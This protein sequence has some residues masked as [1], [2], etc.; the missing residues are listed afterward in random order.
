MSVAGV[1]V[2]HGPDPALARGVAA[3]GPQVDELVV[4]ANPPAPETDARLIVNERPLG[5]AAN[6][7]K[8]IAA[9][10]APFVVLANPDTEPEPGAVAALMEFAEAHPLAGIVGPRLVF[11]DGRPQSSRR[12][13]PTVSGTLVRRTPL[14]RV[15]AGTQGTHYGL[16]EQ[17]VGPVEADWLLGAFVLLRR[18]ML[19]ELGGFDDRF[20]LYGEEI[21]LAYRAAKAG[22]E[23]WYLPDA[24]VCHAHAAVTDRRFLTRRTLWHW[25]GILRFVRKHPEQ[26]VPRYARAPIRDALNPPL[27][28]SVGLPDGVGEAELRNFLESVRVTDGPSEE[29]RRYA[30]GDFWRFV[31][32]WDFVR[33]LQGRALELG[34]NPY[35]TTM[36]LREFTNLELTLANYFGPSETEGDRQTARELEQTV[37]HRNRTTGELTETTLV[38]SV[39]NIEGGEF[40][41]EDDSFDVVLFCEIIEHL[42]S[43]PLAALREIKR[44]LKS[45]GVLVLTTPNVNRL[46]NVVRMIQGANIYDPYSGYGAYGR[47]NREYNKHELY[48]LLTYLGFDVDYLESANVQDRTAGRSP[49]WGRIGRLVKDRERDLGQY[50]FARARNLRPA[51]EK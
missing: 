33:N 24:V 16:D 12:R 29:L 38:S 1:V 34:A 41:F 11:P 19:D 26:L 43:D 30:R 3:L 9:T 51:G 49:R 20:R 35:F 50:L 39:F 4:V 36:L 21:D 37:E 45:D 2:T 8:G 47:H 15:L 28:P 48:Q 17:P 18:E 6:A 13:F 46:E 40:P 44:V 22:W 32:T 5:F 10:S 14:R 27:E 23:R 25:R 31:R 7:N 42:T